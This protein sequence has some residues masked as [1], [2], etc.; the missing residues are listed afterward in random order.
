M[1]ALLSGEVDF[2]PDPATQDIQRLKNNPKV[3]LQSGPELRVLMILR[4]VKRALNS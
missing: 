3:K 1:A 2:V 4:V